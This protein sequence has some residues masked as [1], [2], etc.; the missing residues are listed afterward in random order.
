MAAERTS[1][2]DRIVLAGEHRHQER[3]ITERFERLDRQAS[4]IGVLVFD[5]RDDLRQDGPAG[6]NHPRKL[7]SDRQ[8]MRRRLG[9]ARPGRQRVFRRSLGSSGIE[10]QDVERSQ[11]FL[12]LI[13]RHRDIALGAIDHQS[14]SR[15]DDPPVIPAPHPLEGDTALL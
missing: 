8:L 9:F 14:R 13:E 10:R 5:G 6:M 7:V 2:H 15:S 12:F 1:S 3:H 11:S 4:D